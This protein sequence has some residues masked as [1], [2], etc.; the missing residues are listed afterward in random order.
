MKAV[1]LIRKAGDEGRKALTE[2]EAK[3]LLE[4]YGVPVVPEHIAST[5]DEAAELAE[6]IGYPVVLK[7]MG[8]KLTHKTEL[9]LVKL[10]IKSGDELR[11]A[12]EEVSEAAGED[13]EAFLVQPMLK[14]RRE[15]VAGFFRDPTFG[16]VVMFGL[17]GIFTE[18]LDDVCFRVA[19]VNNVEAEWM[20][21]GIRSR[22]LLGEFRGEAEADRELLVRTLTGLSDLAMEMPE[23]TEVD[24]NPLLIGADGSVSAVDALVV[25][26]KP[27][28]PVVDDEPV[29]LRRV[30][31]I[32]YPHSIAFVGASGTIG[33]WGHILVTNTLSSGYEGE[34]YLVNPKGGTIAGQSVYKSLAEIPGEIDL[35]VVTIPA[36]HVFDL[37]PQCREKGI[38]GMLLIASGFSETGDEGRELEKRLA[39][40]A[41]ENDV[42]ILGP[43]TMG[44][45]NPHNRL[46]CTASHVHPKP[47]STALVSQSGNMGVQLLGF[48]EQED[49]G[50]RAFC[51]SG[52]EAMIT[53]EDY[54]ECF[55]V[56]ELTHS[57]VLYVES[58]T[59]G[60]RFIESARRVGKKKPVIVL[61]GG[62]TGEGSK[63]A[64]SHTGALATDTKVLE[65]ACRQ[66]GIVM[67]DNPMDLLNLSAAFAS[68]PLPKG[69]RVGIVTLGGGWGV[70]TADLCIENGLE[71]PPLD[72][73]I[74][75]KIDN[76]LPAYWSR[77]NPIDLVGHTD[78]AVPLIITEELMKWDGCDAVI[79]LGILGKKAYVVRYAESVSNVDPG[80]TSEFI[81][82][83]LEQLRDSE[84]I[85]IDFT[86][87]LM[88]KYRKPIICVSLM[89]D[90]DSR[91]VHPNEKSRYDAVSFLTPEQAV[92]ALAGMY[93]Y[94]RW[95]RRESETS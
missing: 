29:D 13:L 48:A 1:D 82:I 51:G 64:S 78:P 41:R 79:N 90:S 66:A 65:A 11:T 38:R 74:C 70:I 95:T 87:E 69:S 45:C 68:L 56:D 20:L 49:I 17:G 81:G 16:P 47:G 9:G 91:T 77:S 75:E 80:Y 57:V 33:K 88:D 31:D 37:L 89:K 53:I 27:E 83:M 36:K 44:I 71:V 60:R 10:N 4:S 84:K 7:G 63:A 34:V 54:M 93:E 21:D 12:A 26:G 52:N 72:K 85:Y 15:F 73:D 2:A 25:L 94:R 86:V 5:P 46:Y 32:F 76:L 39:K 30:G 92:R 8:A 62:R 6:K 55:E 42:L 23:V 43:N 35:V 40:E 67:V 19:P 58:V 22:E 59:D 14:G 3:E 61:R 18:A 50:I 24:I 28:K